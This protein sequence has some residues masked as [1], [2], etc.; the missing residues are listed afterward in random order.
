M[1]SAAG[2][3]PDDIQGWTFP[4]EKLLVEKA[5]LPWALLRDDAR[6]SATRSKITR[7]L[8]NLIESLPHG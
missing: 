5:G 4:A 7:V 1:K 3:I 8:R 6:D 2:P